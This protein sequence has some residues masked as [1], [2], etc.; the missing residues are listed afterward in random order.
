MMDDPLK[1]FAAIASGVGLG[2]LLLFWITRRS[3][4]KDTRDDKEL[5]LE[6][7]FL[8]E[9]RELLTTLRAQ[10]IDEQT[11][12]GRLQSEYAQ[13]QREHFRLQ[14]DC[15]TV[16]VK[17]DFLRNLNPEAHLPEIKI[18]PPALDQ[19]PPPQPEPGHEN[20]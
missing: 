10:L 8:A 20:P 9:R 7:S 4:K 2:Q 3:K 1:I 12:Y 18:D 15:N 14:Q 19:L 17:Y 16:I 11:K 6:S 5:T 13:L